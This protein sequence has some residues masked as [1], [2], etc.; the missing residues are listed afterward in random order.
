MS[1]SELKLKKIER[2]ISILISL[3]QERGVHVLQENKSIPNFQSLANSTKR[4]VIFVKLGGG[5][6]FG[7]DVKNHRSI[8]G[9]STCA[10]NDPTR[11]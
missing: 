1:C 3:A 5:F 2:W 8:A 6:E 9:V 11:S 4:R 10:S 7:P